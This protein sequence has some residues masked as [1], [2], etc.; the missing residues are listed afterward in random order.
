MK[1]LILMIK[2]LAI[3]ICAV[4]VCVW[5]I[6]RTDRGP[7]IFTIAAGFALILMLGIF[8]IMLFGSE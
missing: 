1:C 6:W 5:D 3:A 7:M 8:G 4:G 2:I